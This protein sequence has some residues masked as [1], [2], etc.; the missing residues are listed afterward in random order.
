MPQ[1]NKI[2]KTQPK[3][4]ILILLLFITIS[5]SFIIFNYFNYMNQN[6]IHKKIENQDNSNSK[7]DD[8][9]SNNN[10]IEVSED[11]HLTVTPVIDIPNYLSDKQNEK[12]ILSS[13]QINT[14]ITN[15]Q[16]SPSISSLSD[17]NFVVVW[18]SNVQTG[19][20]WGIYGQIFYINGAKKGN[21]FSVNNYT[22]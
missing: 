2:R 4:K 20:G 21:E 22:S 13:T 8:I 10:S 1:Q 16:R 12:R 14:W 7:S 15:D 19:N 17:G 3:Y 18:Q 6:N 11:K 5:L 9:S